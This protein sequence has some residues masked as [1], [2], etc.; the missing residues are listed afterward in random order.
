MKDHRYRQGKRGWKAE[1]EKRRRKS[2]YEKVQVLSRL[3]GQGAQ[4]DT[5]TVKGWVS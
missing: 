2:Q 5:A 3:M 1:A 4:T